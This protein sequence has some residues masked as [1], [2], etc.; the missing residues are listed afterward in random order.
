MSTV[1]SLLDNSY[2]RAYAY[3]LQ[4]HF[5]DSLIDAM[6]SLLPYPAP[7][8]HSY[9]V[10]FNQSLHLNLILTLALKPSL[11][12]KPFHVSKSS[13][14]AWNPDFGPHNVACRRK[15]KQPPFLS[16]EGPMY[17]HHFCLSNESPHHCWRAKRGPRSSTKLPQPK[18]SWGL[19]WSKKKKVLCVYLSSS[20]EKF[21]KCA[22]WEETR[23]HKHCG[24]S[25]SCSSSTALQ[26]NQN[27]FVIKKQ[28]K[29]SVHASLA[30]CSH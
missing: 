7:N 15:H 28:N 12:T 10:A 30:I 16:I 6:H 4:Q 23:C 5:E 19:N 13:L 26:E 17:F 20:I 2:S 27:G 11:K 8:P 29:T 21:N 25:P 24:V 3:D 18:I 14:C 1:I 22:L 9:V